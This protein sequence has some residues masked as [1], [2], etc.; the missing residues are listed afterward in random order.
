MKIASRVASS[1]L[2]LLALQINAC[3]SA[4]GGDTNTAADASHPLIGNTA[5]GFALDAVNATEIASVASVEGRG[6][7][8]PVPSAESVVARP[9]A[10]VAPGGGV[11][12]RP[13]TL[14]IQVHAIDVN[15]MAGRA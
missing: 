4:S 6:D 5:P 15:A 3:G 7:M 8:K 10:E 14:T 11:E 12:P 13:V 9:P 2:L 1:L